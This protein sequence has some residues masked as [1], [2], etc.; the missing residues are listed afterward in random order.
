MLRLT[1][2][3][4]FGLVA[5]A[6]VAFSHDQSPESASKPVPA[7]LVRDLMS[8]VNVMYV[9]LQPGYEDLRVLSY[10]RHALGAQVRTLFVTN[11][12]AG[13][14]DH[15][16]LYPLQ[17]AGQLRLEATAALE[18]MGADAY[19]LNMPDAK[20]AADT[21]HLRAAWPADSL[22][23]KLEWQIVEFKP[24]L[25]L[26]GSD[27]EFGAGLRSMT[28]HEDVVAA[29]A[30]AAARS[31]APWRVQRIA[32]ETASGGIAVPVQKI[33][34]TSSRSYKWIGD[35]AGE[36]YRS[37]SV[38]R[39]GWVAGSN[40]SYNVVWPARFTARSLDAGLPVAS[41]PSLKQLDTAV[42]AFGTKYR[43]STGG[44]SL[45]KE[46]LSLMDNID[47]R[48]I[49]VRSS[50]HLERRR[51]LRWKAGLDGIRNTLLGVRVEYEVTDTILTERQ[52]TF[53]TINAI[54]GLSDGGTTEL[55][56]P[57]VESGWILNEDTE[58]RVEFT[59]PK[60]FRLLSSAE[61]DLNHPQSEYGLFHPVVRRPSYFFILHKAKNRENSFVF[62][63]DMRLR[64]A[65]RFRVEVLSPIV[66]AFPGERIPIRL[67]NESRDGVR[68]SVYIN[69]SLA[70]APGRLFRLNNKGA[71]QN[72]TLVPVWSDKME[73][74]SHLLAINIDRMAVAKFVA[75]KIPLSTDSTARVAVLP[76]MKNSTLAEAVRR[77]GIRATMLDSTKEISLPGMFDVLVV[78]RRALSLARASVRRHDLEEFVRRGG[79]LVVLAQDRGSLTELPF[80]A[81]VS[82]RPSYQFDELYPVA[83]DS[84]HRFLNFPNR[85]R[86]SEFDGWVFRKAYHAVRVQ[87]SF[88]TPIAGR[89]TSE[90]LLV[91]RQSGKGRITYVD[92][93]LSHQWMNVH[94][95]ALKLLANLLAR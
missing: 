51:L 43:Q 11:G 14:A 60:E 93:A 21:S 55:F 69:D 76:A 3:L 86:Q 74:G 38:Q 79:H 1:V 46:L 83:V 34:P 25:I 9:A 28:I 29:A 67:T 68:D 16:S 40:T 45:L 48:L 58:R 44:A 4:F 90:P 85:I 59:P 20:A 65:P 64:Y 36:F 70:F 82:V 73:E 17:L 7:V 80:F 78:D 10:Y 37:I 87:G 57:A 47:M 53:L 33:D 5:I 32:V 62:R 75:R 61:L 88:E 71:T 54:E 41:P 39:S 72:D 13:E 12:E 49:S 30:M 63:A 24:D 26:I 35:R 95:G 94:A 18:A 56:V 31:T 8:D 15:E 23:E 42:R 19:F 50:E 27:R 81:A 91:T 6:A 92:L 2:S 84:T 89:S 52:V 77:L 22:R 66:R